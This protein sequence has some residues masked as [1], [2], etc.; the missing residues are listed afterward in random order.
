[1]NR[2]SFQF[3]PGDWRGNAN[4][5]RCSHAARGAWVDLICLLHDSDEYGVCRWPLAELCHA[6]GV[7]L[8][9]GE[10]LRDKSV[11]K[12][13]DVTIT[14]FSHTTRHAGQDTG[15]HILIQSSPGPCWYSSRMVRDEW[16]RLTR[17]ATTR[18]SPSRQPNP[19]P[20]RRQGERQGI[21]QGDGASSLSSSSSSLKSFNGGTPKVIYRGKLTTEQLNIATKFEKALAEQ[22]E[23]DHLKWMKRCRINSSK[24]DRVANE[25][26]L[27]IRENRISTTPAQF[28]EQTWKEFA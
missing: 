8:K 13:G 5:R 18:F 2:P 17:G 26:D 1:M 25:L 16:L 24:A 7:P 23:K 21:P 27:A 15:T 11:L 28:A 6:A 10:E 9:L 19:S 12:G 20:T 14:E 4:L 22:W 3:Y